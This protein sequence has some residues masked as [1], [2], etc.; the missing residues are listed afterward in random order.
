LKLFERHVQAYSH[1]I[2]RISYY[3]TA[4]VC[5]MDKSSAAELSV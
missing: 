5:L 3:D 2:D 1:R 4:C